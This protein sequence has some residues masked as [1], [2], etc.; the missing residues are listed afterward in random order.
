MD[1][2]S[3]TRSEL[4]L[5]RSEAGSGRARGETQRR[6]GND[7]TRGFGIRRRRPDP[8]KLLELLG[9]EVLVEGFIVF[10]S[11]AKTRKWDE[12]KEERG[13]A[14]RRA[15]GRPTVTEERERKLGS[16]NVGDEPGS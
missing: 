6:V 3:L 7:E 9:L 4:S 11:D 13:A 2:A 1:G 16:L 15:P 5:Q 14:T 8:H 10:E 12:R